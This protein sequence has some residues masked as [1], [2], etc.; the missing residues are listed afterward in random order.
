MLNLRL[1]S[2]IDPAELKEKEGK[3]V[4]A[5]DSNLLLTG[6]AEVYKPDG[7]R[8]CIYLPGALRERLNAEEYERAYKI[9]TSIRVTT[10]N[11]GL[12]SGSK[13]IKLYRSGVTSYALPVV[14]SPVGS[15]E[16]QGGRNPLC[17]LTAWTGAHQ[18]EFKQLHPYF[19]EIDWLFSEYV[20]DR[21]RAQAQVVERTKP[22]WV[23]PGTVFSTVTVNNTYPTGVHKDAGDFEDGFSCLAVMRR[24]SY[25]G[26]WLTFPEYRVAV[27]LKDGDLMLMDA[28]EWHGNTAI[29]KQSDDAERISCVL[30][31]RTRLQFCD[32]RA[33]EL[34]KAKAKD[35]KRIRSK[36]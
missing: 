3:I 21:Y 17:R 9:L 12:A 6:P 24:G 22:D 36:A 1:R 14:S 11:R 10:N 27:D 25:A 34:A 30:Y 20:P 23:I 16:A 5:G 7:T 29:E 13:R 33:A 35:T 32:T 26:G 4:T 15:I 19:R 18:P 28:H 31:Y 8:L 2:R